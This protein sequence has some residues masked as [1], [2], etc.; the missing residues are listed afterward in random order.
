[1]QS[2]GLQRSMLASPV[3]RQSCVHCNRLFVCKPR[4]SDLHARFNQM[5]GKGG[6]SM[7]FKVRAETETKEK[8]PEDKKKDEDKKEEIIKGMK[9]TGIDKSTAQ[10]IL[11]VALALQ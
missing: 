11:K 10:R 2:L 9:K 3:P 8:K 4:V 5:P 1:M 7:G 6:R